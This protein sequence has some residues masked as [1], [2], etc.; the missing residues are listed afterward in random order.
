MPG[1]KAP[2][3]ARAYVQQLRDLVLAL[4]VSDARMDQGSLRAT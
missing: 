1:D 3:V 4:D 2:A